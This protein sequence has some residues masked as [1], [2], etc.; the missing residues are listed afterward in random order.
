MADG[1]KAQGK[2]HFEPL[3]HIVSR[4]ALTRGGHPAVIFLER[5]ESEAERL[6][7]AQLDAKV[8][9]FC[10]GLR[11]A[12]LGDEPLVLALPP[13][14]DFIALF[15]ACL[16]MGTIA[17]P[18]PQPET[19]NKL[20]RL[21]LILADARP[22]AVVTDAATAARFAKDDSLDV[23]IVTSGDLLGAGTVSSMKPVDRGQPAFVQYTSGSTR[24]PQGIVITQGNL[25]A[26]EAMIAAAF[27]HD[28]TCVG[29]S[30]LPHFHDMGLI[31]AILQP[32]FQG[33]TV[34][35]MPPR[36]FIQR[37]LR[38]LRAIET[39]GGTG[40][41]GP[42]FGFDLC[43]RMVTAEQAAALDLSSW[44][45]AF[46]G[47]EPI[48]A[49]TLHKFVSHFPT[50]RA[51]SFL[52]CYGMAEATLLA[53]SVPA[54]TG[55]IEREIPGKATRSFVSCG[56]AMG[57]STIALRDADGVL[58]DASGSTGEICV[59]GPHVSPGHWNG[60]KRT[61]TPFAN[62][63][64]GKGR[65]Y[66]PTGDIGAFIDG[67]LF[68]ID[69]VKDT[70]ILYGAKLHAVDVEATALEHDVRAVAA[71]SLDDGEREQLVLL[72]ELDRQVLKA[73]DRDALTAKVAKAVAEAHGAVPRIGLLPYGTLPRTSSGKVQRFASKT[74]V[75][76]GEIALPYV[77][78]RL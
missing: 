60:C 28:E 51:R 75:L 76:S 16:R 45:V 67:E 56:H 68:P 65:R 19:R 12:Q 27:A 54:N 41:G 9:R 61:V 44:N 73:I 4:H 6:S 40:A 69:R 7:Y 63:F 35:L 15:L 47:A 8:D 77:A 25:T 33:G 26:N 59:S 70:I 74:K 71:F 18:V 42:C 24:A 38:W 66:L 57:E 49:A 52:P 55:L 2:G 34:V 32:L 58:Q 17:I 30:W 29:V 5:G 3:A 22:A 20:E 64:A 72:C 48:R 31:G 36:A 11:D 23:R 14:S 50:F 78:A 43:T 39:Y 13:G 53:A 10:A 37:P 46:C 62:A 1:N 21:T